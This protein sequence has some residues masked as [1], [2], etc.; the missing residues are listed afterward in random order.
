MFE[1]EL[2]L[3]KLL[4]SNLKSKLWKETLSLTTVFLCFLIKKRYLKE[5]RMQL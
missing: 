1:L 2:S 3:N 5:E 4:S